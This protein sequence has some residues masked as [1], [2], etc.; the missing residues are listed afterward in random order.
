MRPIGK[1]THMTNTIY[2]NVA[3]YE[4]VW[5]LKK[6]CFIIKYMSEYFPIGQNVIDNEGGKEHP[7]PKKKKY[8]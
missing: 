7:P 6:E 2:L 1:I 5:S 3:Q 8:I 4:E